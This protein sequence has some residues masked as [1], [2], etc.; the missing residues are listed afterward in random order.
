MS[1]RIEHRGFQGPQGLQALIAGYQN[2]EQVN[3]SEENRAQYVH[4]QQQ[5]NLIWGGVGQIAGGALTGLGARMA[6]DTPDGRAAAFNAMTRGQLP[7]SPG[8]GASGGIGGYT[9]QQVADY[10]QSV[11][12]ADPAG[13]A[14]IMG[15]GFDPTNPVAIGELGQAAIRMGR[16]GREN[17]GQLDFYGQKYQLQA[18]K[19][20]A[21]NEQRAGLKAEAAFQSHLN[22]N[23]Q[24]SWTP[25]DIA[26]HN[27]LSGEISKVYANPEYRGPT[28]GLTPEAQQ[29]VSG[30]RA[31]QNWIERNPRRQLKPP[32]PPTLGQML[33]SGKADRIGNRVFWPDGQGGFDHA[34]VDP[35]AGEL[36][37]SW[38]EMVQQGQ[39]G[40]VPG[41]N[42]IWYR[43]NNN[44]IKIHEW[45]DPGGPSGLSPNTVARIF[46][47][48]EANMVASMSDDDLASGKK[49]DPAALTE[50][51][52]GYVKGV[53]HVMRE[54]RADN[55]YYDTPPPSAADAGVPRPP[56][57]G[58]PTGASPAGPAAN[59]PPPPGTG[60]LPGM[61]PAAGPNPMGLNPAGT[62]GID[63]ASG[64]VMPMSL[65]PEE[66]LQLAQQQYGPHYLVDAPEKVQREASALMEQAGINPAKVRAYQ[67]LD[68]R[69][70]ELERQQA[71]GTLSEK[72][73][74]AF[75]AQVKRV[76]QQYGSK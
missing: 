54:I 38:D 30:Y 74:L 15:P 20:M 57:G 28:G 75:N 69:R 8:Y 70:A 5:A 12:Q 32:Q 2:Q 59:G 46:A 49:V 17:A 1:I 63:R 25:G 72:D 45:K 24:V 7:V 21:V 64:G 61:P 36:P 43:D 31:E 56:M 67:A 55:E 10:G 53:H 40:M 41:Q 13:A 26:R 9:A 42:A 44:A 33:S 6:A 35:E 4:D 50:K 27:A 52:A 23:S 60:G 39:A 22:E 62:P 11:Y 66:T 58:G 65:R 29:I 3:Q 76:K 71:A 48:T 16:M 47:D 18:A 73:R 68:K 37:K 19:E 51:V 14:Q 34:T